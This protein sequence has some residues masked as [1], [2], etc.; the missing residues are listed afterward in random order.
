MT[1]EWAAPEVLRSES[2]DDRADV[3]S[4]GVILW[5]VLTGEV[6]WAELSPVQVRHV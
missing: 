3:F 1:P 5:E 4:F 6:P 2:F